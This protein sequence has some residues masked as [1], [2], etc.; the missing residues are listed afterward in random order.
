[1]FKKKQKNKLT[2]SNATEPIK[3]S[4]TWD[5]KKYGHDFYE[6][7]NGTLSKIEDSKVVATTL[8]LIC[9]HCGRREHIVSFVGSNGRNDIDIMWLKGEI[10]TLEMQKLRILMREKKQKAMKPK[11]AS[12]SKTKKESRNV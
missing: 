9:K 8:Y 10:D 5:C 4:E 7:E 12:K 11:K 1:M 3:T 2:T 6:I